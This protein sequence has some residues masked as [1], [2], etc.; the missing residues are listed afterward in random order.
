MQALGL[1]STAH[2]QGMPVLQPALGNGI[3]VVVLGAGIA[4]LTAAYEL[5]QAGFLVTL[6]AARERV[7]GRAWT[8]RDGDQIEMDG[9]DNQDRKGGVSGKSGSVRVGLGACRINKKT[10]TK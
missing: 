9:E 5:E 3:H 2:A 10:K 6:L 4:G 8:L 1:M 7:G